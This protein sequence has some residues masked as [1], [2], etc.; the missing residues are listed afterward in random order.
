MTIFIVLILCINLFSYFL[1]KT[2]KKSCNRWSNSWSNPNLP[3][4]NLRSNLDLN[5]AHK[6]L[7]VGALTLLTSHKDLYMGAP[8]QFMIFILFNTIK[9]FLLYFYHCEQHNLNSTNQGLNRQFSKAPPVTAIHLS[10]SSSLSTYLF[11]FIFALAL[12]SFS[13]FI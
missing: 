11:L 6:D 8:T 2:W 1:R 13:I 4:Y 3:L 10:S 5:I 9:R 12:F 7:Y